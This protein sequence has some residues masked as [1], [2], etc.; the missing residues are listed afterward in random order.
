MNER[1]VVS[2][3]ISALAP[4]EKSCL[5]RLKGLNKKD[6]IKKNENI[7]KVEDLPERTAPDGSTIILNKGILK[8]SHKNKSKYFSKTV[9]PK[10]NWNSE[11]RSIMCY[12]G[13]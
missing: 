9:Y 12:N 2:W 10:S 8:L 6:D 1:I 3:N 7:T 4:Q 11:T 5:T 13:C